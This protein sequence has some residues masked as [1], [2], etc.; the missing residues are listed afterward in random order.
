M[1]AYLTEEEI[2]MYCTR[3]DSV[4]M[5][6]V[7]IASSLI[8][9]YC[10]SFEVRPRSEMVRLK[11][12]RTPYGTRLFGRLKHTPVANITSVKSIIQNVFG[13]SEEDVSVS[14]VYM[15]D[16]GYF[17]YI[18]KGFN[19]RLFGRKPMELYVEYESGY[20]EYPEQL[21]VA[22]AILAQNIVQYGGFLSWQS[23]KDIDYSIT[24]ADPNV[25]TKEIKLMLDGLMQDV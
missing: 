19:A 5:E 23:K 3:I 22:C 11:E 18:D 7:V 9:S 17:T 10:G 15:E 12:K 13:R 20:R 6:D 2:L 8:D 21:K 4:T 25:F 24:L 16:Y 14:S 1:S